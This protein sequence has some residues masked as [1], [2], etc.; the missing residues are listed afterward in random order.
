[1]AG[2][3]NIATK[4]PSFDF[5][6]QVEASLTEYDGRVVRGTIT[7]PLVDDPIGNSTKSFGISRR[8]QLGHWRGDTYVDY[9]LS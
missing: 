5:D 7:A 3:I 2:A 9:R 4:A 8:D 1:M 6:Y